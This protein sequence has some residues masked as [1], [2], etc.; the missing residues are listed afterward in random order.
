MTCRTVGGGRLDDGWGCCVCE[1]KTGAGTYNGAARSV[2][3]VCGHER[4]D[5]ETCGG[6]LSDLAQYPEILA[7]LRPKDPKLAIKTARKIAKKERLG[8]IN[9]V[10]SNRRFQAMLGQQEYRFVGVLEEKS[11]KPR[12]LDPRTGEAIDHLRLGDSFVPYMQ[13]VRAQT[14]EKAS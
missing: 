9:K 14:P 3:K 5:L 6:K 2:C 12:I 7:V 10:E 8:T 4:C 1:A 13:L 11:K